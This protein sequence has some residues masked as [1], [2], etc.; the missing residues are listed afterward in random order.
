MAEVVAKKFFPKSVISTVSASGFNLTKPKRGVWVEIWKNESR[1]ICSAEIYDDD[2]EEYA[3][4]GLWI[5]DGELVDYDGVF[6]MPQEVCDLLKE[7][8]VKMGPFI[9]PTDE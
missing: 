2:Q 6:E 4:I 8:G 5:E 9:E 1:G 7:Q 3:E